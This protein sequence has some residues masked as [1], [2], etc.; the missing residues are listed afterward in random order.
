MKP[1]RGSVIHHFCVL[2]RASLGQPT[3]K[4][5]GG[6]TRPLGSEELSLA[7]PGLL[8]QAL[9][10]TVP[11]C[12][13]RVPQG[14]MGEGGG[15]ERERPSNRNGPPSALPGRALLTRLVQQDAARSRSCPRS[16]RVLVMSRVQSCILIAW[17]SPAH[18]SRFSTSSSSRPL[19]SWGHQRPL[20]PQVSSPLPTEAVLASLHQPHRPAAAQGTQLCP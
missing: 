15:K 3:L 8:E 2:R 14:C 16:E 4:G 18:L 6:V 11:L 10:R 1:D 5:G 12:F 20:T 13:L 7:R 17:Q 19:T 9:V